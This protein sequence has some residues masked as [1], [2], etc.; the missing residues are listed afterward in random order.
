MF[1][2][3]PQKN[4]NARTDR[5]FTDGQTFHIHTDRQTLHR[6]MDI[7]HNTHTH[8][9]ITQTDGRTDGRTDSTYR[10]SARLPASD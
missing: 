4:T 10:R 3:D 8:T 1:F 6:H 5:Q 9:Y 7:T 2:S